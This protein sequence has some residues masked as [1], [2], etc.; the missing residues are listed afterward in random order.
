MFTLKEKKKL[1]RIRSYNNL[2]PI[3]TTRY[4]KME[5]LTVGK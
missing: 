3:L 2:H 4:V 5:A 1:S